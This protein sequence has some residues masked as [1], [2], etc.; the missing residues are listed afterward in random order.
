[1]SSSRVPLTI[2]WDELADSPLELDDYAK[3]TMTYTADGFTELKR[4]I[5]T[6]GLLVPIILR[7][8]K[9]LDGRHRL[10]A[11]GELAIDV[12]AEERG[13]LSDAEALN[14]VISNSLHKSTSSDAARIEAYLLCLAKGVKKKDMPKEFRRLNSNYVSKISYIE[15]ANP[16]YLQ[17]LLR[18]NAVRLYNK[19]FDK[20]ED[21]GTINGLWKALKSNAALEQSVSEVQ[22]VSAEEGDFEISLE[23]Y[24]NNPAAESEFWELYEIGRSNGVN[25]HPSSPVGSKI[26]QLIKTKYV[27]VLT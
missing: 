21:Y 23:E 10:K 15:G 27:D 12:H 20:V 25:L 26:L 1:M 19:R 9:V 24:F 5:Q 22:H 3:L 8:G 17:V 2:T 6:N 18:Q 7:Q 4:D 11:C 14:V 16:E 13:P